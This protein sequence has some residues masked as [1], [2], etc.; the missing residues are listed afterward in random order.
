MIRFS[1]RIPQRLHK[2]IKELADQDKRS[3]NN[4]IIFMLG[5]WIKEQER[6]KEIQDRLEGKK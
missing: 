6:A 3:M 1:L 2:R 5:Q 4:Q